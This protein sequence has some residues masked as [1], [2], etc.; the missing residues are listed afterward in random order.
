M[1]LQTLQHSC[2]C[3]PS[4]RPRLSNAPLVS[5]TARHRLLA[6]SSRRKNRYTSLLLSCGDSC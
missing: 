5:F 4:V 1:Q 2:F 6:G 3:A